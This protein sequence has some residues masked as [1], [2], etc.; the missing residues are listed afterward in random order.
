MQ[1]DG[2]R[3]REEGQMEEEEGETTRE[4]RWRAE[5]GADHSLPA[6]W[7]EEGKAMSNF[8]GLGRP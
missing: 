3:E 5:V 8:K 2:K 6:G 4:G 7:R 1:I